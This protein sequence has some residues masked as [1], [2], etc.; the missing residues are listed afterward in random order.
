LER[1]LLYSA[2]GH[3]KGTECIAFAKASEER[4]VDEGEMKWL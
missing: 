2:E 1:E 3:A 4:V